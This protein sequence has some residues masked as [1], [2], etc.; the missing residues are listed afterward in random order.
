MGFDDLCHVEL[1][2]IDNDIKIDALNAAK[3]CAKASEDKKADDILILD[4]S[5]LTSFADYFV[6]CS[7]LSDRQVRAIVKSVE[8]ELKEHGLSSFAVEGLKESSWVLI[9]FGMV[10]FHCFT[11]SARA[12]YDLEG[13][14]EKAPV[15]SCK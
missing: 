3:L 8:E 13:F 14:W 1:M 10:V 11:K 12:Y 2:K 15:I 5:K 7:A 9:D 6:I 4:V